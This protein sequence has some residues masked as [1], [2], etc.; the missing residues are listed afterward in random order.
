MYF[1]WNEIRLFLRDAIMPS[2]GSEYYCVVLLFFKNSR[3][4]LKSPPRFRL[5]NVQLVSSKLFT[6]VGIFVIDLQDF[7]S[8]GETIPNERGK[9]EDFK[10]RVEG[11]LKKCAIVVKR[12]H[13]LPKKKKK[14]IYSS[15]SGIG[16]GWSSF[17]GDCLHK[18]GDILRGW[19]R[20]STR[21]WAR[22]RIET[23]RRFAA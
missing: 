16:L 12:W 17:H 20:L 9:K 8:R 18:G 1:S 2:H 3:L 15:T 13:V 4:P 21:T 14:Y 19:N 23:Q 10:W 6:L 22:A 7:D 5:F 11:E